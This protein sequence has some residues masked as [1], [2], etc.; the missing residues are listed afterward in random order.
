MDIKCLIY[1]H[2]QLW[3][4]PRHVGKLFQVGMQ[5]NKATYSNQ[6]NISMNSNH[7]VIIQYLITN[8]IELMGSLC[9]H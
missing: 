1:Y 3:L 7:Y 8:L 2:V 4:Y 9:R 5:E 6:M